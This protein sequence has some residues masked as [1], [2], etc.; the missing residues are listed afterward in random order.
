VGRRD[1]AALL[2]LCLFARVQ[3]ETSR[4]A[5][6]VPL[7]GQIFVGVHAF[8]TTGLEMAL[9]RRSSDKLNFVVGLADLVSSLVSKKV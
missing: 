4:L 3:E 1:S 2:A 5:I 9:E 7:V 8:E 6:A